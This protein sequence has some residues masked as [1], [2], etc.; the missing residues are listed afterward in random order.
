MLTY[1]YSRSLQLP[2]EL[3]LVLNTK[4]LGFLGVS[5]AEDVVTTIILTAL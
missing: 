3:I 2:V 5:D 4:V 1:S